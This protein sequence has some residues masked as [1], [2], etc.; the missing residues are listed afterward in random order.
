MIG[1][2]R[3]NK[4]LGK[5]KSIRNSAVKSTELLSKLLLASKGRLCTLRKSVKR[6]TKERE[7]YREVEESKYSQKEGKDFREGENTDKEIKDA[8]DNH[9]ELSTY[10]KEDSAITKD[11][12]FNIVAD[13]DAATNKD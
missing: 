13:I 9:K 1:F 7:E 8:K 2:V 3:F 12:S 4:K 11:S 10:N 5:F 6:A